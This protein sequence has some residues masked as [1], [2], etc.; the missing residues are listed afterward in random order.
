LSGP[1]TFGSNQKAKETASS[2]KP[3]SPWASGF[4][5]VVSELLRPK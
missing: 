4:F 2:L 5:G 3:T 1:L